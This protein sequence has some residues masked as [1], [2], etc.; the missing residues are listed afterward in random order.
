MIIFH[1]GWSSFLGGLSFYFD[2]LWC[3]RLKRSRY[4]R[5]SVHAPRMLLF[6]EV[7]VS[8]RRGLRA[9]VCVRACMCACIIC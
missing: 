5:D 9:C 8:H 6:A 4:R 1:V 7:V 2:N 3:L